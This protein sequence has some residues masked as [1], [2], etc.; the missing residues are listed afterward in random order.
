MYG[1]AR[2]D[3]AWSGAGRENWAKMVLGASERSGG[4][5][6]E[7]LAQIAAPGICM[8]TGGPQ[9]TRNDVDDKL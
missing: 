9:T 8:T 2:S 1:C 5:L 6:A 4:A 3:G 7:L